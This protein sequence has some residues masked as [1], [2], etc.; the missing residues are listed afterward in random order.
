MGVVYCVTCG[1][2]N[3]QC[4]TLYFHC[5]PVDK[6]DLCKKWVI[7]T[8]LINFAPTKNHVICS[9]HFCKEDYR[10]VGSKKLKD[11][12]VPSVFEFSTVIKTT[13]TPRKPSTKRSSPEDNES[14]SERKSRK[15][16]ISSVDTLL[17]RPEREKLLKELEEK[18]VAI[19]RRR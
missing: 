14:L 6:I 2:N 5:F 18:D 7:A 11:D 17:E 3:K 15:T 1:K 8:R 12:A 16:G 10:H 9:N 4:P 13:S 19:L